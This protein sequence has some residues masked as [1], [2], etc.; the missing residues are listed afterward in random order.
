MKSV[1]DPVRLLSVLAVLAVLAVS[2]CG[3][4]GAGNSADER[5]QVNG[6]PAVPPSPAPPPPAPPPP[7][8]P[9][10]TAI[11]LRAASPLV[12]GSGAQLA[13]HYN[14]ALR[15]SVEVRGAAV[16]EYRVELGTVIDGGVLELVFSNAA[17]E[18]GRGLRHLDIETLGLGS[19]VL[20]PTD[21]V[22]VFDRGAGPLAFDGQGLEAGRRVL[23]TEGAL[24]LR[25]PTA[26]ALAA[27][28]VTPAA[29]GFYVD[30]VAGN[31]NHPGTASQ[32]WRSLAKAASVQLRPGQG[33]FLRCGSVWRE[34]LALNAAQ[35][36]DGSVLAGYGPECPL[37][38]ALVSGADEFSGSWQASGADWVRSVPAGTPKI[39]QLFI[40]GLPLRTAQWPDA[41]SNGRETALAAGSNSARTRL[42]MQ[43]EDTRALAGR[44]LIGATV[45]VRSKPWMVETRRVVAAGSGWLDLDRA[46]DWP[47]DAG[48]GYVLQDK[49]WMLDAPGEFFHDSA[50][51]RLQLRGPVPGVPADLNTAQVEGSVRD[52]ALALSQRSGLVLRDLAFHAAREDGLRLI[53][54]PQAE[55]QRLDARNNGGTGLLLAQWV[56]LAASV[57]GPNVTDSLLAGNGLRGIDAVHV[58]R[59]FISRNRAFATGSLPHHQAHT[60]AGIAG[61]PGARVTH[62]LID[63]AG[64]VGIAFS[65]LGG[66]EISHNTVQG[67]CLRLSDCG[68]IYTWQGRAL[69][70][71]AQAAS[72]LNNRVLGA[73][74]QTT[75]TTEAG[76]DV[77]AGIYID[78]FTRNVAVRQNLLVGMP[79]GVFAHNA[80]DLTIEDNRIWLATQ[81][82]LWGSM[83]QTD[84]DWMRGNVWRNNQIV[85][86]V[87]VQAQPGALPSFTVSQAVWF[88]HVLDGEAALAAGRNSFSGNQVLQLQGPLAA[89]VQLRGPGGERH[90]DPLAWQALNPGEPLPQR[91]LHFE[92]LQPQLGPE[93]V[94][95]GGFEAGLSGWLAYRNPAGSGHE[96]RA[97]PSLAGCTGGCASFTAGFSDDLLGSS[98]FVLR[99]GVPH[100][101]RWTAVLPGPAA[102]VAA[103]YISRDASPWDSMADE[104]GYTSIGPRRAAVAGALPFEAYFMP[105]AANPAR[106]NLQLETLRQAVAF[107]NVSV[108]E[109][110]GYTA[111]RPADWVALAFAPSDSARSVGCAE[112][113]WPAGCS[114]VGLDGQPVPLPLALPAGSERLLMRADSGFRR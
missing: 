71:A 60:A 51:Q 105:K 3:G 10:V 52:V 79:R 113:G 76:N 63:G 12:N 85:P 2:A 45:Q 81:A 53:D 112:L 68:G 88:W 99:P 62:N 80:S 55:L 21:A 43:A 23:T 22:A 96:V 59:A 54:A 27:A 93:L 40:N 97:L 101:F 74:A 110:T 26:Q 84:A 42:L 24:R 103:P 13:V 66:S 100:V 91:P 1:L 70:T 18:Q 111:A 114:A 5:A 69:A 56:P 11:T 89:H 17:D 6:P 44:D 95:N 92:A 50:T 34:T 107:D 29:A 77:V 108:R 33:L 86:L 28:A 61:G 39:S 9:P 7:P 87:Q 20:R 104:R 98:A 14:G 47:L 82:G 64:Y 36:A 72:V 4:G 38:R 32:P 15:G 67:Y 37:R 94:N 83:G 78:D 30:A 106:V 73:Q 58:E 25:L 19:T 41:A 46:L 8:P 48:E 65:A 75:G 49:A 35:L 57:P 31:D 102:T 109:V 16:A 90:I